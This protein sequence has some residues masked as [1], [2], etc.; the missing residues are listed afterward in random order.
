MGDRNTTQQEIRRRLLTPDEAMRLD[1]D[2]EV[3]FV[4]GQQPIYAGKSRY[5]QDLELER[6]ASIAPP[7]RSDRLDLARQSWGHLGGRVSLPSFPERLGRD[8][9]E[10]SSAPSLEKSLGPDPGQ[11]L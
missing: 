7:V 9:G 4:A 11:E 1:P 2:H 6:R 10:T 3:V 5:F 8:A